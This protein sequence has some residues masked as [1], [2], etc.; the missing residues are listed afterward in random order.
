LCS[1]KDKEA[2]IIKEAAGYGEGKRAKI[3][4]FFKTARCCRFWAFDVF[5]LLDNTLSFGVFASKNVSEPFSKHGCSFF[6]PIVYF[7]KGPMEP[8]HP[9][10]KPLKPTDFNFP[11]WQ[12]ESFIP[13][14]IINEILI[15]VL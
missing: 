1:H 4:F 13:S 12:T 6:H 10:N 8:G 5:Y 14:K 11:K 9:Y 2:W 15:R 3:S 7:E